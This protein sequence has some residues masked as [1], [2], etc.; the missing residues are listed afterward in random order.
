[1]NCVWCFIVGFNRERGPSFIYPDDPRLVYFEP[2]IPAI[3]SRALVPPPTAAATPTDAKCE[4][5]IPL[6]AATADTSVRINPGA[7][8]FFRVCYHPTML[9][10]ILSALSQHQIPERDR[11]SLLDDHF[12]L[13]SV[14]VC[15]P[16]PAQ[17][18]SV[19]GLV[20]ETGW[21]HPLPTVIRLCPSLLF[22]FWR[23]TVTGSGQS[24]S[25]A[26]L[27]PSCVIRDVWKRWLVPFHPIYLYI[28]LGIIVYA[29]LTFQPD[30]LI[31]CSVHSRVK[32]TV[33][34][35]N[36]SENDIPRWYVK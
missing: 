34:I 9:P 16:P 36:S 31:R 10:P 28:L 13:V 27:H 22:A 7:V 1:M 32:K 6:S 26:W 25:A 3:L 24:Q 23:I 8:G 33:E 19:Y 17:Y 12:A 21:D 5:V 35:I 15:V 14:R 29:A 11:L 20:L 2:Q 4:H 30:H 18:P